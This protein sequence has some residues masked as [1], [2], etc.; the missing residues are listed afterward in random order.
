MIQPLDAAVPA[1]AAG[2]EDAARA[3]EAERPRLFAIAY[4]MLGTVGDAEDVVS[5]AAL[6]W[7]R[8][9]RAEVANPGAYLARTTVN[10]AMDVARSARRRREEYVGPWLP[11]PLVEAAGDVLSEDAEGMQARGDDLSIAFLLLLERLSPVE[12]AVFLLRESF[13]FSYREIAVVV[14]K[15]ETHCRQ[16]DRRARLRLA[17]EGRPRPS[18]P[19]EHDRL[20]GRFLLATREG[21]VQGLVDV[22]AADVVSYSDSGGKVSSA[23]NPVR[24]ADHVARFFAGLGRKAPPDASFRIV[25]VNG[26]TGIAT[27]V[28]G[29]LFNLLTVQVADGRISH[30]F[31]I[32]NPDKLPDLAR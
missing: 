28:G 23:R 5:E 31:V 7:L 21:D 12:R 2:E 18:D 24:G 13:D 27:F 19:A 4:R 8:A 22:L 30:V 15:T 1:S 29:V 25:R 11:E 3:F 14:G 10:L 20:L 9:D 17:E 26:R 32:V 16:I 6:R